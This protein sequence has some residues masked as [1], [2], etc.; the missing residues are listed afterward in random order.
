MTHF[1]SLPPRLSHSS[2]AQRPLRRMA[3]GATIELAPLP[4]T[5]S[6]VLRWRVAAIEHHRWKV[7]DPWKAGSGSTLLPAV[8][9]SLRTRERFLAEASAFRLRRIPHALTFQ[10]CAGMLAHLALRQEVTGKTERETEGET[11]VLWS[12]RCSLA[13]RP[14]LLPRR[15]RTHSTT[16]PRLVVAQPGPP[17]RDAPATQASPTPP[18]SAAARTASLH[19]S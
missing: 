9:E 18:P 8:L 14:R 3:V 10:R 11:D 6:A 2:A 16:S 1:P 17:P 4:S 19:V 7:R 13:L 12:A 5:T 15:R